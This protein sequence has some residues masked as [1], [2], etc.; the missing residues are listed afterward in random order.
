MRARDSRGETSEWIATEFPPSD[1]TR[2]PGS[3]IS[4]STAPQ[5]TRPQQAIATVEVEAGDRM[6]IGDVRA[7]LQSKASSQGASA[8][9]GLR[10]VRS[11]SEHV[12]FAADLVRD[13][14][15]TPTPI[16]A[17]ASI[18]PLVGTI[19]LPAAHR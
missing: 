9:V 4:V 19:T 5:V 16:A 10:L 17:A 11:D 15:A 8:A 12:V 18:Q 14:V 3:G 13:V 7:A 2:R 6:T 1:D